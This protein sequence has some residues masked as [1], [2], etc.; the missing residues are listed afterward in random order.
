LNKPLHNFPFLSD[1]FKIREK[2]LKPKKE[3]KGRVDSS[4]VEW[5]LSE[6]LDPHGQQM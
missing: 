6:E 3:K 1:L 2:L 5:S 4:Y